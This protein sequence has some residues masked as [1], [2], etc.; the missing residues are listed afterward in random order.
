MARSSLS[1]QH[2]PGFLSHFLA[3]SRSRN[4]KRVKRSS[5]AFKR[6]RVAR[7]RFRLFAYFLTVAAATTLVVMIIL[8]I[9]NGRDNIDPTH[10]VLQLTSQDIDP[11]TT[12]TEKI[13]L[14]KDQIDSPLAAA[15]WRNA[16]QQLSG[17]SLQ[18]AER[19][20]RDGHIRPV[21][22]PLTKQLAADF[23]AGKAA[24][25]TIWVVEDEAQ[26]GNAVDLQLD[27]VLLGKFAIEQ[28][29]YAITVVEKVG[30]SLR[31]EITGASEANR[32]ATFRAETATSEAVTR[33]LQPGRNDAWQL[34]VK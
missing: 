24:A 13:L 29:R 27:G 9:R 20:L 21:L 16:R 19:A 32:A 11:E 28:N 3:V 7:S 6:S 14:K 5:L 31:L 2:R 23:D 10:K 30:E 22:E 34:V 26:R 18:E 8:A 12:A 33:H 1:D 25:F 17:T 4:A 15:L